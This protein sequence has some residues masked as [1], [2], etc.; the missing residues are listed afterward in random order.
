MILSSGQLHHIPQILI[1]S[2]GAVSQAALIGAGRADARQDPYRGAGVGGGGIAK[3]GS[4]VAAPGIHKA[5]PV[6]CTGKGIPGS[7][8]ADIHQ[9]DIAVLVMGL[10]A[11]Q[12]L[13]RIAPVLRG[14]IAQLIHIVV[15]PGPHKPIII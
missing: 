6:Y 5:I 15:T 8:S 7:D 10:A 2:G 13:L 4:I 9:I 12:N 11:D 1:H 3:L 14:P